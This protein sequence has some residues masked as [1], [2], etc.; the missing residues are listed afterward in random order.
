MKLGTRYKA[1]IFDLDGTLI[2]SWP[3]LVATLHASLPG[4]TF[5]LR[6]LKEELSTGISPMF[7]LATAQTQIATDRQEREQAHLLAR[8]LDEFALDA[9]LYPGVSELL[10][11]LQADGR[12]I[13]ICTN[14]DRA[15]ALRLLRHHGLDAAVNAL[16]CLGDTA[17]PKPHPE[18]LQACLAQLSTLPS[19][20]LFV[21]DSRIDAQ[22]AYAAGVPFAAHLSGYHRHLNDLSP[23]ALRFESFAQLAQLL[24]R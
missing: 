11:Q 3:S 17:H 1:S 2:D 22:C 13:G 4:S 6:L 7:A 5:D 19:Q 12:R 15:S 10:A 9:P 23:A 14:R 20:A 8:Y 16:I 21:G 24:G 18:P